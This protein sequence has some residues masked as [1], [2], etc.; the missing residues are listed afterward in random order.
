MVIPGYDPEDLDD[1][2]ESHMDSH[3][4]ETFLT[5]AEW[6]SYRNGD[7]TLVDLLDSDELH[8]LVQK[9]ELPVDVPEDS[10]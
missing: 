2:L 9:K 5:D 10:E 1:M 7:A 3:E 8:E 6:E 4:I